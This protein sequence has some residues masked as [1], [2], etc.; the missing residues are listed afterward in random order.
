MIALVFSFRSYAGHIRAVF[1]YF[2]VIEKQLGRV[3]ALQAH[4]LEIAAPLESFHAALDDEK[5]Q[6]MTAALV[7]PC[8]NYHQ[9]GK[10]AVRNIGLRAV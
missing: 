6:S 4:L 10:D 5:T 3:L 1:R 7:C 9:V 8:D 2:D